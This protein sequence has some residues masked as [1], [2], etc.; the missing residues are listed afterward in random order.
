MTARDMGISRQQAPYIAVITILGALL[1]FLLVTLPFSIFIALMFIGAGLTITLVKIE[2]TLY[3]LYFFSSMSMVT[4]HIVL[5]WNKSDWFQMPFQLYLIFALILWMVGRASGVIEKRDGTALD[6]V[7]I[8]FLFW[9]SVSLIWA[10]NFTHSVFQLSVLYLNALAFFL[11]SAFIRSEDVLRRLVRLMVYSGVVFFITGILSILAYKTSFGFQKV[12]IFPHINLIYY[13]EAIEKRACGF[14]IHNLAANWYN[15]TL[16]IAFALLLFPEK[17][18]IRTGA[19][20]MAIASMEIGLFLTKSRAGIFS[21]IPMITFLLI[22]TPPIRKRFL[23]KFTIFFICFVLFFLIANYKNPLAFL[24]RV[25]VS[26]STTASSEVTIGKRIGYWKDGIKAAIKATDGIGGM[27][28]G[29][30]KEYLA[31][32][33][34]SHSVYISFFHDFGFVGVFILAGVVW[35]LLSGFYRNFKKLETPD[36]FPM[37]ILLGFYGGL[38]ALSLHSLIEFH[39]N[40]PHIWVFLGFG[41][42]VLGIVT[43]AR[44]PGALT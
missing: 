6:W 24:K 35:V 21:Q 40:S 5:P 37:K 1:G 14:A 34:H 3:P 27:G 25:A 13:F 32:V 23:K 28:I 16:A 19:L 43:R 26:V 12:E 31:P 2:N 41:L 38:V 33:P 17:N 42:A 30:F 44:R 39:Y 9:A 20:V 4:L 10:R 36:T 11:F 8:V 15:L 18:Y 29:G 7:L 22:M